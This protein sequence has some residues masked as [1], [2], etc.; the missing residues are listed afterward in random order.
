MKQLLTMYNKHTPIT[1]THLEQMA[2]ASQQGYP[3]YHENALWVNASMRIYQCT[4]EPMHMYPCINESICMYH[5][6]YSP[7][8][9]V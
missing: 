6:L 5:S 4:T 9:N 8:L 7:T 3:Y 1:L 2:Q